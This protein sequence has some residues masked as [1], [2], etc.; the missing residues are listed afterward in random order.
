MVGGDGEGGRPAAAGAG[1]GWS[2]RRARARRRLS[3][4]CASREARGRVR[5]GRCALC[6][7]GWS[8][9]RGTCRGA[10]GGRR[11]RRRWHSSASA[12]VQHPAPATRSS[13]RSRRAPNALG[14]F[15]RSADHRRGGAPWP[16][17]VRYRGHRHRSSSW[18][19]RAVRTSCSSRPI[20]RLQVEHTV[21]E[22]VYRR[23][24]GPAPSSPARRRCLALANAGSGNRRHPGAARLPRSRLRVNMETMSSRDGG[25][26]ALRRRDLARLRA[27]LRPRRAGRRLSAMPATCHRR[28]AY[29][30][31]LAKLI[32]PCAGRSIKAALRRAARALR[33]F[34]IEGVATN[35]SASSRAL[36]RRPGGARRRTPSARRWLDRSMRPR[37]FAGATPRPRPTM[38]SFAAAAPS[39]QA[40][41]RPP[42]RPCTVAVVAPMQ[43][44]RRVAIDVG[45][46]RSS[47][48]SGQAARG[49]RGDEDGASH[50]EP[51]IAGTGARLG[52][53]AELRDVS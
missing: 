31:L 3:P 47:C 43:G 15:A 52:G 33:E 38:R 41:G 12:T 32:G 25:A 53:G 35:I 49:A 28:P 11:H 45:G 24:P 7:G 19:I 13:S 26:V 34:R 51:A 39:V 42:G 4:R 44:D 2:P 8:S 18:S 5:S 30:S 40:A 9:R 16:R 37:S 6:R 50:P 36:L 27:A 21:T 1:C 29:D 20:P 23:R 46:R 14:R 17:A 48:A 22:E 10:G